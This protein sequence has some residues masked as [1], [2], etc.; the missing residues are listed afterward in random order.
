M[1][2][3][4]GMLN[5]QNNNL[6]QLVQSHSEGTSIQSSE[7]NFSTEKMVYVQTA[8]M[9]VLFYKFICESLRQVCNLWKIIYPSI[10]VR[11]LEKSTFQKSISTFV[12]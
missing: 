11:D 2:V 6:S 5:K 9:V 4:F 8:K 10:P 1:D 3:S 7:L 12:L